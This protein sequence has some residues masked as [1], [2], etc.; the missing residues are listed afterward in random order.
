MRPHPPP[1]VPGN[2]EAERFNN[3]VR[4]LFSASKADL[5]KAED[6]FQH[7]KPPKK[8]LSKKTQ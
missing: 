5:L 1:Y 8:R 4:R 3:A 2:T 6:Q 7:A